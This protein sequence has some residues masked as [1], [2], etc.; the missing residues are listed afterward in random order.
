MFF[1]FTVLLQGLLTILQLISLSRQRIQPRKPRKTP[2]LRPESAPET[3]NQHRKRSSLMR[4]LLHRL[5]AGSALGFSPSITTLKSS[6]QTLSGLILSP[7]RHLLLPAKSEVS[8]QSFSRVFTVLLTFIDVRNSLR[9]IRAK[10]R[11]IENDIDKLEQT[12]D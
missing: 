10:L 6:F 5:P 2:P 3:V 12:L 7:G 4:R 11:D 1:Y 8:L 9:V